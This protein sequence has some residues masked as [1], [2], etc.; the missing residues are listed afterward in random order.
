M[1]GRD[2]PTHKA[3]PVSLGEARLIQEALYH[4]G[5]LSG[6]EIRLMQLIRQFEIE[7]GCGRK[8]RQLTRCRLRA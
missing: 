5:G 3:L 4:R 1:T 6:L 2:L 8:G 7:E